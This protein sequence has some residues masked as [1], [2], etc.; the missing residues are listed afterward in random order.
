MNKHSLATLLTATRGRRLRLVDMGGLRGPVWV[1][2]R[3]IALMGTPARTHYREFS[4]AGAQRVDRCVQDG[5][6]LLQHLVR[7]ERWRI[8]RNDDTLAIK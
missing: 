5:Q 2:L 7:T 6:C 3:K 8:E 1:T 4:Q